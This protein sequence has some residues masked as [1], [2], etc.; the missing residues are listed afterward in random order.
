MLTRSDLRPYQER[1][2]EFVSKPAYGIELISNSGASVYYTSDTMFRDNIGELFPDAQ[3]IFHDCSFSP[4]YPG[5]VHTHYE[6][7]LTLD[8]ATRARIVLM[9]YTQIPEG[10]DV[11]ADGFAGA[12]ARHQKYTI[13]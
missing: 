6:E 7:L 4:K 12:A 9:H 2:V 1:G 13:E 3:I 11:V 5:T 8:D 10:V